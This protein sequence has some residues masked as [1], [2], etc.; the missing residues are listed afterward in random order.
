MTE[1]GSLTHF[2]ENKIQYE[3][4]KFR[5]VAISKNNLN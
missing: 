1:F 4:Q 3:L 2:V 5:S